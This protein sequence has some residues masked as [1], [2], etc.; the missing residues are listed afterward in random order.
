MYLNLA[1]TQESLPRSHY[2]PVSQRA[3]VG[4]G[5]LD[6]LKDNSLLDSLQSRLWEPPALCYFLNRGLSL[7]A[8]GGI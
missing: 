5:E 6:S 1:M 2:D 7:S 3:G 4:G 8:S